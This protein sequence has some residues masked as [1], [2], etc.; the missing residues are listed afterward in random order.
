MK[1]KKDW[2]KFLIQEITVTVILMI[3]VAA[4]VV[5]VDPF[6]HYHAPVGGI[7]YILDNERYQNDGIVRNYEYDCLITGTSE[8]EN[9]KSTLVDELFGVNSVKATYAGGYY[10]EIAEG[11]RTALEANPDIKIVI[12][13]MD[14]YFPIRFR[15]SLIVLSHLQ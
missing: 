4:I 15:S 12:R 7:S 5:F 6:F 11:E 10:R 13:S 1:E 9:F 8:S 2:T 14:T 3:A